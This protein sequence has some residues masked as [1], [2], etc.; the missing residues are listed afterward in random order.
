MRK[1]LILTLAMVL[2]ALPALAAADITKDETVYAMLEANGDV[3]EVLVV[4]HIDTPEDGEYVDYGTYSQVEAMVTD[5]TPDIDGNKITWTLPADSGG[6]YAVGAMED[7]QLPY[8]FSIEYTLDGKSIAPDDLAGQSGRVTIT[9][10]ATPGESADEAFRDRYLAQVQLPLSMA[11]VSDVDAPGATSTLVGETLT[12]T[13]TVMPGTEA[14]HTASFDAIDYAQDSITIACTTMNLAD[15]LGMDLGG[16]S[17]QLTALPELVSGIGELSEGATSLSGGV[18]TLADN[19][20]TLSTQLAA[21]PGEFTQLSSGSQQITDGVTA[22]VD[23]AGQALSGMSQLSGALTT[24]AESGDTIATSVAAL[25]E[26]LAMLIAQLPEAQQTAMTAQLTALTEG[27]TAYT[28]GVSAIATQAETLAS[29]AATLN[30]NGQALTT[31]IAQQNEG[32]AALSSGLSTLATQTASLPEGASALK[33]GASQLADGIATLNDNV[34]AI[35]QETYDALESLQTLTVSDSTETM[36]FADPTH[37]ARSVQF[38][39]MTDPIAAPTAE[40]T[41]PPEAADKTFWERLTA[42]F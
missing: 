20:T 14:S 35:P 17:E 30:E 34:S 23:G 13:Y 18:S 7:A 2:L 12:L 11:V 4:S 29:G 37:P 15:M 9:I 39:F 16:L 38:V 6:F 19:L 28:S 5:H 36:S 27:I 1:T 41:A 10:T 8:H 40:A 25:Q 21:L 42:L 33:D 26:S 32:I 3:R 24:A 31:G 22:Y